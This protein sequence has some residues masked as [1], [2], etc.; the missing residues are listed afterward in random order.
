M[1][2]LVTS[3]CGRKGSPYTHFS[4]PSLFTFISVVDTEGLVRTASRQENA[5]LIQC[6]LEEKKRE[7]KKKAV[8]GKRLLIASWCSSGTRWWTPECGCWKQ[9][10]TRERCKCVCVWDKLMSSSNPT[11]S[12]IVQWLF[13]IHV[14][15]SES[16]INGDGRMCVMWWLWCALLG[17]QESIQ[18][19]SLTRVLSQHSSQWTC[20]HWMEVR[21]AV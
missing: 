2:A 20:Q 14:F 3:L 17:N 5:D 4:D 9:L 10:S 13:T 19:Q 7:K 11:T 15:Q 6:I 1:P 12:N 21:G 8:A 16:G 18:V